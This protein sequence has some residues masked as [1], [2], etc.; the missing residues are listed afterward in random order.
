MQHEHN[1]GLNALH[2]CRDVDRQGAESLTRTPREAGAVQNRRNNKDVALPYPFS[3]G[4]LKSIPLSSFPDGCSQKRFHPS[5]LLTH[6]NR[7]TARFTEPD[8]PRLQS[9]SPYPPPYIW[10]LPGTFYLRSTYQL[11]S[12]EWGHQA[13]TIF[14]PFPPRGGLAAL[15]TRRQS[16]AVS[17]AWR[18]GS[19]PTP[20]VAGHPR[21]H[22]RG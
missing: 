17:A 18:S 2:V 19:G 16:T 5:P 1:H 9:V 4:N 13:L 21:K 10:A 7:R 6:R 14:P 8:L 11:L 12:R 3:R 22:L 15:P 20:H